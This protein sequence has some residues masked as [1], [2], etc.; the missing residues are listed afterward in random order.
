MDADEKENTEDECVNNAIWETMHETLNLV[1]NDD[2]SNASSNSS[3]G[4]EIDTNE[5]STSSSPPKKNR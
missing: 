2:N 4:L 5:P 3:L 1:I